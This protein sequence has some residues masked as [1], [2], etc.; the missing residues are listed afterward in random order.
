M[1]SLQNLGYDLGKSKKTSSVQSQIKNLQKKIKTLDHRISDLRG[2]S[3]THNEEYNKGVIEDL[4]QTI[5][6]RQAYQTQLNQLLAGSAPTQIYQIMAATPGTGV[7]ASE[8]PGGAAP[9]ASIAPYV[10]P[11]SPALVT[12]T[13]PVTATVTQE[14]QTPVAVAPSVTT[15]AYVPPPYSPSASWMTTPETTTSYQ[16]LPAPA[17]AV[18]AP[19]SDLFSNPWVIGGAALLIF[20]MMGGKHGR[21]ES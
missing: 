19:V 4:N 18:M 8:V 10:P 11:P 9:A 16:T 17:P 1:Y 12:A 13:T 20:F 7:V 21:R 5:A 2:M 6:Q 14:T 15:P 3:H